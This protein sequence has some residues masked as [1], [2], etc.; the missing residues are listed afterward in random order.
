MT[1]QPALLTDDEHRVM[2]LTADTFNLLARVVDR[3]PSREHDMAELCAA[4]H[5]IQRTVM[6]QA[7]ARAYPHRYRL[8][9]STLPQRTT[10]AAVID[11]E[12]MLA[13]EPPGENAWTKWWRRP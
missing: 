13:A 1:D 10:R 6:A 9:G 3:G 4:I 2:Q 5:V 8:L 11:R 7:A 12:A